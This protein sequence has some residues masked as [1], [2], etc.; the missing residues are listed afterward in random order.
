MGS[1]DKGEYLY[2]IVCQEVQNT[3]YEPSTTKKHTIDNENARNENEMK[4]LLMMNKKE[5]IRDDEC[6][7][8]EAAKH[9]RFEYYTGD[10]N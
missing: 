4:D 8:K 3:S 5:D 1:R 10:I 6:L 7:T 2:V 9:V